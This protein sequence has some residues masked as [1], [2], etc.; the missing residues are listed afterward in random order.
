MT[1]RNLFGNQR[2]SIEHSVNQFI[3]LFL[4]VLMGGT[5]NKSKFRRRLIF[6]FTLRTMNY[7]NLR[8]HF[9]S[10]K[11]RVPGGDINTRVFSID[12]IFGFKNS[13]LPLMF[14]ILLAYWLY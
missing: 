13:V 7:I 2:T 11:V 6:F 4:I 12:F 8:V 14:T 10:V 5:K 9:S 1:H 3:G